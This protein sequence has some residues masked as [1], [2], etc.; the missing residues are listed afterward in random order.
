MLRLNPANRSYFA[1]QRVRFQ[2]IGSTV[3]TP[4][5]TVNKEKYRGTLV[6]AAESIFAMLGRQTSAF[7]SPLVFLVALALSSADKPRAAV[8]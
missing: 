3:T 2:Q 7:G 1:T 5:I 4:L 8:S 6:G